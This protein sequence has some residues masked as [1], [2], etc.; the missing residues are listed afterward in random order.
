MINFIC[1]GKKPVFIRAVRA[2]SLARTARFIF[3]LFSI[4]SE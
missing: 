1:F 4:Q 2:G 3:Q